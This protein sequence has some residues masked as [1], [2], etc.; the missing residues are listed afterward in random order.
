[1]KAHALAPHGPAP[2]RAYIEVLESASQALTGFQL[3]TLKWK[4]PKSLPRGKLSFGVT[5]R[6]APATGVHAPVLHFA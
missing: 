1:M 3:F 2:V 6:D 5:A 4:L